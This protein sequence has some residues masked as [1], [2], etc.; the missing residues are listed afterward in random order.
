MPVSCAG[1]P[2][3]QPERAGRRR[4]GIP[5]SNICTICSNYVYILR[6]RCLVCGRVY[7]RQCVNIGMG[8]MTEGRKCIE[9]LGRRFSIFPLPQNKIRPAWARVQPRKVGCCNWRYPSM[10]KQVELMWAEKEPRRSGKR[11][12]GHNGVVSSRSTALY[13]YRMP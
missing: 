2:C 8:K 7:C 12:S 1:L 6:N 4:P 10:V 5:H 3:T 13:Q 11:G 9:C